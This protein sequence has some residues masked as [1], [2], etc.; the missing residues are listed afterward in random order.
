MPILER[1]S[2]SYG[3]LYFWPWHMP[4][5]GG[6]WFQGWLL[7]NRVGSSSL[8]SPLKRVF[9]GLKPPFMIGLDNG[10]F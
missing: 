8:N 1:K 6:A 3:N 4:N 10:Y 5:L 7:F 9:L 2:V